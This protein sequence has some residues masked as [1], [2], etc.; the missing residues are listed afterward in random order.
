VA[1]ARD[2]VLDIVITETGCWE[3]TNKPMRNGYRRVYRRGGGDD[4]MHRAAYT[5][6]RGPIPAGLDL[7]HLCRNRGCCNPDHLQPVTRRENLVRGE[8]VIAVNVAKTHCPKGH[9][10]DYQSPGGSRGCKSCNAEAKRREYARNP[11][12][13]VERSRENRRRSNAQAAIV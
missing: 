13:F 8:T 2:W 7:D 4:L 6:F 3:H 12:K 10:Y 1:K 11:M 9:P 5:R